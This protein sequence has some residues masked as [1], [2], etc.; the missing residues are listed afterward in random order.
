MRSAQELAF[1]AAPRAPRARVAIVH[2]WLTGMRGGEKVLEEICLLYPDA[3]IFTLVHVKGS[4]S[5]VIERRPIR[6]SWVQR[7]PRAGRWYRHY[8]LLFPVAVESFDLDGYDLVISSSHCAV[9]SVDPARRRDARLLLPLADAVCLGPVP[10]VFRAGSGR[11]RRERPRCVRSWPGW[12]G[13]T[14]PPQGAWTAFSLILNM[15]R[16]GYAD[17]IIAGRPLCILQ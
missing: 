15:L 5:P 9:K 11:S 14:P 2:D 12:R 4:V 17:T 3:T 13:G 16:A 7:L 8:L 6:T 1:A 10:G